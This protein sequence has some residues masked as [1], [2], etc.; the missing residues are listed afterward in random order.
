MIIITYMNVYN[1]INND[2]PHQ[3]IRRLY[4]EDPLL[5]RSD[6]HRDRDRIM[7]SVAFR[8][9]ANKTQVFTSDK[10][11]HYRNRLTHTLEVS[12]IAR[13]LN[14]FIGGNEPLTEAIS[15]SHDLG[16][17]PFGHAGEDVLDNIMSD[18]QGFD[19]NIQTYRI[20]TK[21]EKRYA[22]FN[23]LNLTTD[24][25]EGVLKHNGPI[26]I[27]VIK[28]KLFYSRLNEEEKLDLTSQPSLEAQIASISDDIAYNCHDLDDGIRAGFFSIDDLKEIHI[29]NKILDTNDLKFGSMD[30]NIKT[31]EMIRS[32]INNLIHDV[33]DE[34]IRMMEKLNINKYS[35][36]KKTNVLVVNFSDKL[37][38]EIIEIKKFLHRNMYK[39]KNVL[40]NSDYGKK[41][42]KDLFIFYSKNPIMLP[43]NWY[44]S[45]GIK[46]NTNK[47]LI[48]DFIACMSDSFAIKKFNNL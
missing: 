8:R 25:L 30:S 13:S 5:H 12:Q 22:N 23:G 10:G 39:N 47:R 20:I 9:L 33:V 48:C 42:L 44:N 29:I 45:Y 1:K 7:H 36:I 3:A 4:K 27:E 15:L 18:D 38:I 32:L 14:L 28:S 26:D 17:P 21:I 43:N 34:T 41:V 11:D 6:Y 37:N 31:Y 19:H 46:D 35:D 2:I 24:T 40:V 16:H